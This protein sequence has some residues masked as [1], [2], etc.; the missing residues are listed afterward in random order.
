M[1]ILGTNETKQ[2]ITFASGTTAKF[3]PAASTTYAVEFKSYDNGTILTVG[4]SLDG[5]YTRTGSEGSYTYADATGTADG[6][7]TYYK[8]VYQ[9]K[10]IVVGS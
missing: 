3:T 9:Y 7:T 10:I 6:S 8:A 4:T 2:D 5:Y 1:S